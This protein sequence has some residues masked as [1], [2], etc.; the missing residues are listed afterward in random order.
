MPN[1]DGEAKTGSSVPGSS[2]GPAP[3]APNSV[4]VLTRAQHRSCS[5]VWHSACAR[6][7]SRTSQRASTGRRYVAEY[8]TG[9]ATLPC[10]VYAVP[11]TDVP[12]RAWSRQLWD[13]AEESAKEPASYCIQS[14]SW[15]FPRGRSPPGP[16]EKGKSV[17]I[18]PKPLGMWSRLVRLCRPSLDTASSG[19]TTNLSPLPGWRRGSRGPETGHSLR[20]GREISWALSCGVAALL[21][22]VRP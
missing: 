6:D 9:T 5:D 1:R 13:R 7:V 14:T 22:A 21:A 3:R 4:T 20:I 11:S 17:R 19:G 12:L 2:G 10:V 8:H 16:T 18:S 15:T